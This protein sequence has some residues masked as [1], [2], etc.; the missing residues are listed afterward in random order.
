MSQT[1][2]QRARRKDF[3]GGPNGD[4]R[5]GPVVTHEASFG[6]GPLF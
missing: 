2:W 5:G 1:F 3:M 4:A 6:G